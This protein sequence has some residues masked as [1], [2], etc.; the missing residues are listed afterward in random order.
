MAT[1]SGQL[2]SDVNENLLADVLDSPL[3]NWTVAL[4]RIENGTADLTPEYV[5]TTDASGNYPFDDVD[6]GQY[7]VRVIDTDGNS[8]A[9]IRERR[10][11]A[12]FA[13]CSTTPCLRA[14][15]EIEVSC[16]SLSIVFG[17]TRS[18]FGRPK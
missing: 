3:E 15:T 5:T 17:E 6:Q 1:L 11:S 4:Y 7:I 13:I 2:L 14:S 9:L 10:R 16:R 18:A 12:S 8:F